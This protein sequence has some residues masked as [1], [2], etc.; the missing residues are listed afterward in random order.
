VSEGWLETRIRISDDMTQPFPISLLLA[1][2]YGRITIVEAAAIG[3]LLGRELE[4]DARGRTSIQVPSIGD[5]RL[6][7]SGH[8]SWS[9]GR[10]LPALRAGRGLARVL[11]ALVSEAERC[12]DR[13]PAALA[14]ALARA[15]DDQALVPLESLHDLNVIVDRLGPADPLPITAAFAERV[16]SRAVAVRPETIRTVSDL[17]RARR[18]RGVSLAT[19]ASETGIPLTLL[20]ELEWGLFDGWPSGHQTEASLRAY[21]RAAGLPPA[22][23][24]AVVMGPRVPEPSVEMPQVP[25]WVVAAAA[26]VLSGAAAASWVS[27]VSAPHT[28]APQPV[29]KVTHV[30]PTVVP[31]APTASADARPVEPPA[32]ERQPKARQASSPRPAAKRAQTRPSQ[33]AAIRPASIKAEKK[34][35]IWKRPL[36]IIKFG[37]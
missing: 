13:A 24:L 9:N 6:E 34:P 29:R 7:A 23:V 17:R 26:L 12:G 19:I 28:I 20:R 1:C 35:S 33:R 8:V 21:A 15:T 25:V 11:A 2:R 18:E 3:K 10:E 30:A 31:L 37:S 14:F 36:F 16:G 4:R 32:V 22:A 5:V 27:G